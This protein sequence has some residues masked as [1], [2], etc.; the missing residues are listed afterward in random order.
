M[1]WSVALNE[2]LR[3]SHFPVPPRP[4]QARASL[5]VF[6]KKNAEPKP[7]HNQAVQQTHP[8]QDKEKEPQTPNTVVH[9]RVQEPTAV[10]TPRTST[11]VKGTVRENTPFAPKEVTRDDID[12]QED[13]DARRSV[14]LYS[15]RISHHLR[16]GSLLSWDNL[17]DASD[18]PSPPRTFR[19]RSVSDLSRMSN[20]Q[21]QLSRHER[22]TSSSGFASSKI[23]S[24]W[25]KVVATEVREDKSSIYSSRP[26]SPPDSFGGSMINLSQATTGRAKN[27]SID[28]PRPR[29]S[30]SYPTD[31][32]DTPRP[33]Q[34]YGL[35]GLRDVTSYSAIKGPSTEPSQ[36]ARNNSVASTKKS[37]FREE[38]SP[39]PPKKKLIPSSS[40]MKFLNP[41]RSST[42]SQSEAHSKPS[43]LET[44]VDGLLEVP[45]AV[46]NHERRHSKSMANTDTKQTSLGH[47]KKL[48]PVWE[49]ALK[50]HQD[51]R[52][53]MFLPQNKD[54][55]TQSSPMRRRSGSVS[56]P[57]SSGEGNAPVLEK[58]NPAKRFSAPLLEPQT[59]VDV[60]ASHETPLLFSRRSAFVGKVAG[61]VSP[62]D[63]V[64]MYFNRQSDN[65]E[66][67]GV[68]G[69]YPSHSRAER[70]LS[71]GHID[72]IDSR[73]FALEAAINFARG[74]YDEDEDA[75]DPTQRLPTPP[76]LP[77]EKKRK[78]KVGNRRLAK[79]NSMTFGKNFLKNYTRIFRS[80]SSEFQKYGYGHRSSI[81]TG[82]MLERPEL[83]ILPGGPRHE[84]IQE[85][86]REHGSDDHEHGTA[87]VVEYG[88]GDTKG[89]GKLEEE[90]STSTI[91]PLHITKQDPNVS[92]PRLDG[93][94][95][96]YH[97]KDTARVWSAYYENCLP[98]F[99][100]ASAE[101]DFGLEDF[102]RSARH[103]LDSKR[104]SVHSRTYPSRFTKHSR[105]ASRVSHA[106]IGSAR[107]SCVSLGEDEA[108]VDGQS[109]VSVRRSTMDL[110]ALYKKQEDTERE[111]VLGL[112][113]MESKRVN[114]GLTGL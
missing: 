101:L 81:S 10:T 11:S 5:E 112:M 17:A 78:K 51:E 50:S 74:N 28:L 71:A 103:S 70:T 19:D 36:L 80:Q 75:I 47:D 83:E 35:T 45:G 38:F 39:S 94:A 33:A 113:R 22:Q 24:K 93:P 109:I 69:R 41:K 27:S 90:N 67:V 3:L 55:A 97:S 16:S 65:T 37:K 30:N 106:S 61:D 6:A 49:R 63:E 85:G 42:R 58:F 111:R 108:G 14:H 20:I 96:Q 72:R 100:R 25:G 77:G 68:W 88:P 95:D 73:D 66:T 8:A 26:Q 59:P 105:N 56:H 64:Q 4:A 15:M 92:L 44:A 62:S 31:N 114:A 21:K 48:I 82:G 53:I 54:L 18:L 84:V 40:I 102:G 7:Q 87:A 89:K 76:L 99:P 98:S 34:R 107:P 91:R 86:S 110:V 43:A 104:P 46:S 57:R 9:I 29:R 13:A 32:D 12:V 52:A 2:S 1:S 79:S 23:P 60:A